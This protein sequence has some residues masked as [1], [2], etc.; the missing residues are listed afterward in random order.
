M[1]WEI[2]ILRHINLTEFYRENNPSDRP[3]PYVRPLLMAS[4]W[5]PQFLGSDDFG[6]FL[7]RWILP[8]S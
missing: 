1:F 3:A 7:E 6:R 8:A 4:T 5:H 2:P